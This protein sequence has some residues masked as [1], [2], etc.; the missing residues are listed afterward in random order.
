MSLFRNVI[1]QIFTIDQRST[2]KYAYPDTT[3]TSKTHR[4]SDQHHNSVV[5]VAISEPAPSAKSVLKRQ[6]ALLG[7][8]AGEACGWDELPAALVPLSAIAS[9]SNAVKLR[10]LFATA[11]I[12][13][14]MPEPQWLAPAGVC[15]LHCFNCEWSPS[16]S[17]DEVVRKAY[18]EPEGRGVIDSD[19]ECGERGRIV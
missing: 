15:C 11:L 4:R 19:V 6:P 3:S 7:A 17:T 10:R 13:K 1:R 9:C 12:A 18:I 16:H 5:I 14:T 2:I 8:C